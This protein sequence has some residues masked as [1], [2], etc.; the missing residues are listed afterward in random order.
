[1]RK[2]CYTFVTL[3]DDVL[4]S[5][6]LSCFFRY[7]FIQVASFL[8]GNYTYNFDEGNDE[9]PIH[10]REQYLREIEHNEKYT[11]HAVRSM[12]YGTGDYGGSCKEISAKMVDEAVKDNGNGLFEV[13]SA[14]TD[15]IF[16]ELTP[17]EREA[18]PAYDGEL[19]IPHG[20]GALTSHTINKRWNRKNELLAD[21][22][23][24][25]I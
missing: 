24:A 22:I 13:V 4:K 3:E 7:K 5:P 25:C 1:M 11:G 14:S 20:S 19:L 10:Q 6:F 17:E 23:C 9:T 12:Y 18:L 15:Q 21:S 16:N 2:F 8:E